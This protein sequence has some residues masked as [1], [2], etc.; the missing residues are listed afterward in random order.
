M[1]QNVVEMAL[2]QLLVVVYLH[3]QVVR[4]Q[5]RKEYSMYK[6]FKMDLSDFSQSDIKDFYSLGQESF[7]RSE[8]RLV[9]FY[10]SLRVFITFS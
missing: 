8:E 10:K 2:V 7:Q 5:N 3:V 6:A 4:L 1:Q 9:P